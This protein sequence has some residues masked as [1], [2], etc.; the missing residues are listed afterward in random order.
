VGFYDIFIAMAEPS[1]EEILQET[2]KLARDNN[3]MLHAMRRNAFFGGIFKLI[4]YA[5]FIGIPLWFFATYLYPM[6]DSTM[7]TLNQV[8]GQFQQ[9]QGTGAQMDA[10]LGDLSSLMDQFKKIPG[11]GNFGE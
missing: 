6:L 9:V 10:Q 1:H 4:T 8:Q 2:F 3:R 11:M 7:K 5:L